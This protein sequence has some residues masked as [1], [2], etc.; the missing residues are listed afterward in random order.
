MV[1]LPLADAY[2]GCMLEA[3]TRLLGALDLHSRETEPPESPKH[4]SV[5]IEA[6]EI[7]VPETR[8]VPERDIDPDID[9]AAHVE[10]Y[11]WKQMCIVK[12]Q[13]QTIEALSISYERDNL[14]T[15]Y[16]KLSRIHTAIL[17]VRPVLDGIIAIL[18][19][20]A[21]RVDHF[22]RHLVSV[23]EALHRVQTQMYNLILEH[24]DVNFVRSAPDQ[25]VGEYVGMLDYDAQGFVHV[26]LDRQQVAEE[27][28][29][30]G[31]DLEILDDK[32]AM[33]DGSDPVNF[34]EQL[35]RQMAIIERHVRRLQGERSRRTESHSDRQE[36]SHG[37]RIATP[38]LQHV[39]E[40][41]AMESSPQPEARPLLFSSFG[42]HDIGSPPATKSI[43]ATP[44]KSPRKAVS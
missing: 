29:E 10:S 37:Q 35:Q 33:N 23:D 13:T 6:H 15:V 38:P 34:S 18:Q 26:Q 14:D 19:P 21:Q 16:S 41:L 40:A 12:E 17:P 1:L 8:R 31:D 24:N 11:L 27:L 20:R 32:L 28:I 2:A 3:L 22:Q 42:E 9:I 36:Q 44:K 4:K 30:N 25:E 5:S 7:A 43:V 39:M